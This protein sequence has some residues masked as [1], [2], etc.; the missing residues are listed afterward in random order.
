MDVS[1]LRDSSLQQPAPIAMGAGDSVPWVTVPDT[2]VFL[3]H[4]TLVPPAS[5]GSTMSGS[6]AWDCISML[7]HNPSLSLTCPSQ[8]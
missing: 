7:P 6:G 3:L 8:C 2:H 5:D 1:L 4:R